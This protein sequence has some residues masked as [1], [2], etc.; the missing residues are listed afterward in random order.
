MVPCS[1][2]QRHVSGDRE[3]AAQDYDIAM[4]LFQVLL[5][6]LDIQY[7][8]FVQQGEPFLLQHNICRFKHN[9]QRYQEEPYTLASI[10]LWFLRKEEEIVHSAELAEQVQLLQVQQN[11]METDS[12][13][14]IECKMTD[15]KKKVQS[16]L[17][18]VGLLLDDAEEV[19]F[20]LVRE[21]LV[22]WQ[23]RHQKA[24]IGAPDST[25]LDQLEKWFTTEAESLFQVCKFLKLEELM[26]KVTYEHDPLKTQ[27]PALQ[28][29]VD[30]LLNCLLKRSCIIYNTQ[31]HWLMKNS[32]KL[33]Q[34][35][36]TK[37]VNTQT[38]QMGLALS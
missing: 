23:R 31:S 5:E 20:V 3:H 4:V 8:R 13:W 25:C 1:V 37:I 17:S 18:G 26:G 10:I 19:L 6:N 22:Q 28:K 32:N 2:G 30:S 12:Q 15:L 9:F 34:S 33:A 27:K 36:H 38:L 11:P 24:C 14:N 29:R 7:S 35:L 21:E 16:M